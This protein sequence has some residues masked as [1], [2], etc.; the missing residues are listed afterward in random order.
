MVYQTDETRAK[1]LSV[2]RALFTDRGLFDT[3]ML[4]VAAALGMSRTT[5]YRYYRD[6][7][8]LALAILGI[9]MVEV[10]GSWTDPGPSHGSAR[11]RLE[12]YFRQTWT[13]EG[14]FAAH[15]RYFAEFDAF[16]SGSRIPE[17]FKEKMLALIPAD[18]DPVLR[19]LIIE[20]QRD[21]SIRR[22][23]DPYLAMGTLLNTVR[24]LQQRVVLRGEVL[25]ELRP[26]EAGR[27]IDELLT[28]LLKGISP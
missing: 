12:L 7:L 5:L 3:Q 10:Q 6:K 8:D 23:L 22:D 9:L 11:D 26:A 13:D 1:I 27:L 17:G 2:A 24:G 28:Y 20:G 21:G 25:V 18:E 14:P 16:F 4:D 19:R 15:L